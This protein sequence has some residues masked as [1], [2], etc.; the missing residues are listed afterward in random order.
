MKNKFCK[1]TDC[2]LELG[3]KDADVGLV[4]EYS[5]DGKKKAATDILYRYRADLLESL[6]AVQENLYCLDFIIRQIQSE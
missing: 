4:I 1:I 5:E 6:H 2:L 3:V